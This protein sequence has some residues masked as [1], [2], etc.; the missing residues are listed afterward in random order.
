MADK[1]ISALTPVS[2]VYSTDTMVIVQGGVTKKCTPSQVKAS[3]LQQFNEVLSNGVN[4]LVFSQSLGTSSSSYDYIANLFDSSGNAYFDY[5]I[6]K[7]DE[8]SISVTV[9][10][11]NVLIKLVAFLI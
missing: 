5:E 11:A 3:F 6:S 4:T 8:D 10:E 2:V 1:K 7:I 9:N